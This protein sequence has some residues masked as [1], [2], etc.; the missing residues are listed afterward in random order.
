MNNIKFNRKEWVDIGEASRLL[1]I[2]RKPFLEMAPGLGIR[3][4]TIP[5]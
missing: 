4:R 2:S 3:I 1:G 5:G